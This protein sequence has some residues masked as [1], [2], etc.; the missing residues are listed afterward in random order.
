MATLASLFEE[1]SWIARPR[2][3]LM[4]GQALGETP[5]S[6]ARF[7]RIAKTEK[8]RMRKIGSKKKPRY[9]VHVESLQGFID[10]NTK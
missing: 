9:Y 1:V 6:V 5:I 10:A 8:F 2:A 7:N 4:I 3:C